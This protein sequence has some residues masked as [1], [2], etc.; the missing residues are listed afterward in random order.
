MIATI[1]PKSKI[2]LYFV[3]GLLLILFIIAVVYTIPVYIEGPFN[4]LPE[5]NISERTLYSAKP[6]F[7]TFTKQPSTNPVDMFMI[8]GH[9]QI[10][11]LGSKRG[12]NTLV[13]VEPPQEYYL[14]YLAWTLKVDV[15]A[16]NF[17]WDDS[18]SSYWATAVIP[19]IHPI[20]VV[21][22]QFPYARYFSYYSYIGPETNSAGQSVFGQAST[23]DWKNICNPSIEGNCAGLHD[24]EIIPDRDSMNPFVDPN[25]VDGS[26]PTNYTIYFVS[27]DYLASGGPLP[28]SKNILPLV[29]TSYGTAVI[30]YRIYG[31]F[32]P[33]S[34]ESPFYWSHVGF[35][36]KGCA[37]NPIS[38]T[39]HNLQP[40]DGGA[41]NPQDDK[42]NKCSL[43]DKNCI[44]QCVEQ[45]V[46]QAQDPST[47]PYVGAN[48]C[49]V[50]NLPYGSQA[51]ITFDEAIRS[52]TQ[53]NSNFAA[54]CNG[55]CNQTVRCCDQI[56]DPIEKLQCQFQVCA[57]TQLQSQRT[58]ACAPF[59]P[60]NI[61]GIPQ[62]NANDP[63]TCASQLQNILNN[64]CS[65]QIFDKSS[66]I[67][68]SFAKNCAPSSFCPSPSVSKIPNITA[69]YPSNPS[70]FP[71]SSPYKDVYKFGYQSLPPQDL[72][73]QGWI[74]LPDVFVK[75]SFNNYFIKLNHWDHQ[76]SS[77]QSLE[78][79]F[80]PYMDA[81]KIGEPTQPNALYQNKVI[82]TKE[83]FNACPCG[84]STSNPNYASCIYNEIEKCKGNTTC[85]ANISTNCHQQ[86]SS[87]P[88][89]IAPCTSCPKDYFYL[90]TT[91][92]TLKLFKTVEKTI[93]PLGCQ[94]FF[95]RCECQAEKSNPGQC[96]PYIA[97]FDCS[98]NPC[99]NTWQLKCRPYAFSGIAQP[100]SYSANTGKVIIFPNP[101][102][103]YLGCCTSYD[104]SSVYI[105]WMD[106]PT[107][108]MT[109]DYNHIITNNYDLRYFSLGHYYY[110]MT[111]F[112]PRPVLS[113]L[114]DQNLSFHTL[115]YQ[116]DKTKQWL[117]NHRRVVCVLATKEQWMQIQ[118]VAPKVVNWLNWGR[119]EPNIFK[120]PANSP[121]SQENFTVPK[122]AL[123]P[124]YGYLLYRQLLANPNFTKAI[125]NYQSSSC[126]QTSTPVPSPNDPNAIVGNIGTTCNPGDAQLCQQFG[127]DP[128]CV[129]RG[130]LDFMECYYPRCEKVAISDILSYQSVE[131]GFQACPCGTPETN[132][133]Y[134]TCLTKS[135]ANCQGN[136]NCITQIATSCTQ[137]SSPSPSPTPSPAPLCDGSNFF[138]RY[139]HLPLP[140]QYKKT[141]TYPS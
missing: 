61:C 139:I 25:Y 7:N 54:Y 63:S 76:D 26:T 64:T 100:F 126:V 22:G 49:C 120:Q 4:T 17:V 111:L 116:D 81:I 134:K 119:T 125:G 140:Y 87:T 35:N 73:R 9:Y 128:C 29:P 19:T 94:Y 16:F 97:N 110:N 95:D 47:Y 71:S 36:T 50:C 42:T 52:C 20:V 104:A 12:N 113:D 82:H 69:P 137:S 85:I 21:K 124:Q 79:T 115:S 74:P 56:T 83:E 48:K 1:Y 30:V 72:Q 96:C 141:F 70:L 99:F 122:P 28:N 51:Q 98:G 2:A 86:N 103:A 13:A 34:C 105:I 102:D 37:Q 31:A 44:Q 112:H 38:P 67:Y 11:P 53:N 130:I 8:P 88:S 133:G 45:T 39:A 23:W 55:S 66:S 138:D 33:K 101:D 78:T 131:E 114:S 92:A 41:A 93:P 77:L 129:N 132:P 107:F 59:L 6:L 121:S 118:H 136:Y 90:G 24:Q 46:Y 27:G 60:G 14:N 32:N 18:Q 65:Q 109:P 117:K 75:Y 3:W 10:Y 123:V 91:Y 68:P 108:P 58:P 15:N 62:Q 127:L 80:G 43:S 106:I 84:T 40:T 89:S 135:I 57:A 5:I